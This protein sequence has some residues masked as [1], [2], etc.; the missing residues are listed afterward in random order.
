M[1]ALY[2]SAYSRVTNYAYRSLC[3]SGEQCGTLRGF[4]DL[5]VDPHRHR[6]CVG[7]R[8]IRTVH[9]RIRIVGDGSRLKQKSL[10]RHIDSQGL[11]AKE[12]C[13]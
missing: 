11:P 9:G 3:S 12:A 7:G 6:A 2:F 1:T 4:P 10:V 5:E 13:F 8:L